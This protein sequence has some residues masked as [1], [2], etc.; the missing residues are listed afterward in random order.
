MKGLLCP[1]HPNVAGWKWLF[2]LLLTVVMF[3]LSS[4][5]YLDQREYVSEYLVI[6]SIYQNTVSLDYIGLYYYDNLPYTSNI[7]LQGFLF[8]IPALLG[9][10]VSDL[11]IYAAMFLV[12]LLFCYCVVTMY[13]YFAENFSILTGLLSAWIL[14][15]NPVILYN[16]NNLYWLY[17]LA[18]LP[19]CYSMKKAGDLKE[20]PHRF[21]LT[22]G[23][24]FFVKYLVGFESVSCYFLAL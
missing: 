17:G 7:G 13:Y 22:I 15:Y 1:Q 12:E 19:S 21:Y 16:S 2:T 18:L 9:V 3:V 24:L 6:N 10:S 4:C 23:T 5:V 11:Y 14:L 8:S 20:R